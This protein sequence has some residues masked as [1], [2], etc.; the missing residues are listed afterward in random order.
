M[1]FEDGVGGSIEHDDPEAFAKCMAAN[2]MGRV[3]RPDEVAKAT[4]FLAKR[5]ASFTAGR[6]RL[7]DAGLTH[8]VQY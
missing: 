1:Y 5:A 7:V 4:A 2:P 3:V 6:N 8:D